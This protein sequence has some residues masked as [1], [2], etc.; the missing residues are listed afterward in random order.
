M[1]MTA[2]LNNDTR[3]MLI[4][5]AREALKNAYAPYSKFRV[6]AAILTQNG[7]VISACNVENASY[8]LTM[9]AERNSIFS[10]ISK[11]G[12]D[13]LKII[14]IAVMNNKN[15]FCSPCG[16]CRQVISEFCEES[17]IVLF[18]GKTGIEQMKVSELLP[19]GFKNYE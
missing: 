9:C 11:Y 13:N 17:A 18:Q 10:A 5:S 3:Q 14:A 4:Q 12:K 7:E 6:G 16:A 8:S 1:N 2:E 19:M 15:I